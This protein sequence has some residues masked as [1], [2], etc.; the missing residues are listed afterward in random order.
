MGYTFFIRKSFL[1]QSVGDFANNF[2]KT[3]YKGFE[4]I[5]TDNCIWGMGKVAIKVCRKSVKSVFENVDGI[6]L[7]NQNS[8]AVD[9]TRKDGFVDKDEMLQLIKDSYKLV[10]GKNISDED[11]NKMSIKD[12]INLIIKYW[13]RK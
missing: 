12:A 4:K 10:E 2:D 11:L 1:H 13:N 8:G 9:L 6:P 3:D 5:V 7:Y